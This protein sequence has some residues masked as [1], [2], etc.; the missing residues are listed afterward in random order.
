MWYIL[1]MK[2]RATVWE[3]LLARPP[4]VLFAKASE[5]RA[6]RRFFVRNLWSLNLYDYESQ[7][8]LNGV[9]YPIRPGYACVIPPATER[10][11]EWTR[12]CVQRACHFRPDT[13]AFPP[14]PAPIMVDAG[15]DLFGLLELF[16]QASR[17]HP[18]QA[19]RANALIWTLLWQLSEY[20]RVGQPTPPAARDRLVAEALSWL[21]TNLAKVRRITEVVEHLG[22]SHGH[23]ARLFRGQTGLTIVGYVRRR[24]I[25]LARHLLTHTTL[26]VK[27][28]AVQVGIPDVHHFNKTMRDLTGRSP[29]AYRRRMT[30]STYAGPKGN[31]HR[32]GIAAERQP[33]E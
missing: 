17:A 28:I 4:E 3:R 23:L 12:P 30:G 2:D 11:F 10:I 32:Q 20:P 29:T 14:Y 25:A 24:R 31:G 18:A 33:K 6:P 7:V 21:E 8:C 16:G 1:D 22:V 15:D 5:P 26:S 27:E 13:A 9:P 19:A